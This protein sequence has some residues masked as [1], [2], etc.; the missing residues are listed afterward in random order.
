VTIALSFQMG[1]LYV[2]QKLYTSAEKYCERGLRIFQINAEVNQLDIATCMHKL[3]VIKEALSDDEGALEFYLQSINIFKNNGDFDK[4]VTMACSLHNAASVYL[5]RKIFRTALDF[6]T[7]AFHTKSASLGARH[8]ETAASQHYLGIICMELEDTETAL[9]HLRDAL[10]LRV[11]CFGKEH[12]DVA[13]TLYGLGQAHYLRDEFEEA[14]DCFVE[15]LRVLRKLGC[16]DEEVSKAQLFLGSSYQELGDFETAI[17]YLEEARR[18]MVSSHRENH[19]DVAQALF[20]LGICFCEKN[21]YSESLKNFK[22]CL[23]IRTTS[24]GNLHIECANTYES[25]GI[26]QQ[27]MECHEDAIHSFE[28][29]LAI[30]RASLDD[31]DGDI[32]ILLHFIGSSMFTLTRFREAVGYFFDAAQRKKHLHG[33]TDEEYAVSVIDLAAAYAKAGDERHAMEVS[34]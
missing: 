22:E 28:R 8:F 15:N 19:P 29:A 6:M 3:G 30:K 13:G 27:K 17:G 26:V 11:E 34:I 10:I 21:Q 1:Q 20:R 33:R 14:I 31:D 24:L 2:D 25:I 4:N 12:R 32:C 23:E 5:R 9:C 16:G 7:E 18:I